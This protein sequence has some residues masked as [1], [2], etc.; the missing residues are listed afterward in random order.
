M[1]RRSLVVQALAA[2]LLVQLGVNIAEA[3]P[4]FARQYDLQCNA[5]HTRPPRL[6]RFGEQ[7]H[8]MGFQIPSAARPE[9]V[10]GTLRDDGPVKTLIDSL[11]LRIVG[12]LFEYS[13]SPR[14]T[15]TKFEPPHEVELFITRP[16]TPS[17]SIYVELEYEPK[18]VGFSRTR[19]FVEREH[20]FG[21][22][23][24]A[25][26]MWNM[27][28]LLG[29]LGAPT[30]KMGGQ[31]MVGRHGGFSMHGPMIMA[32]KVDPNTNFS[33]PTN[34]QLIEATELE[35]EKE[36]GAERGEVHRLPVVP[37]A[38]ASKFFGLFKNRDEREPQ[39]VTDQVMYNTTGTAGAEFHAMINDV[40]LAQVGFLRENEGFNTYG[41][42][43]FDIL[44]RKEL[45]FNVSALLNWGFGVVRG[46]DP[47]DHDH[48]GVKRL[49]RLRYGIAANA[50][51]NA[52]DVYGALIFDRLYGVP[53]ELRR[54]F[55]RSAGGRGTLRH[56]AEGR[57]P[58]ARRQADSQPHLPGG[59]LPRP[60]G[61]HPGRPPVR[62]G[63]D[64]PGAPQT[65]WRRRASG[66]GRPRRA[67]DGRHP[68]GTARGPDRPGPGVL[69]SIE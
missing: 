42:L 40:L 68:C 5:C 44:D 13:E 39:L 17:L 37:Y 36:E 54:E 26:F 61:P 14:E 63:D 65:R 30:M 50:R 28:S 18:S 47:D 25:F 20:E 43:R 34:R 29:A 7:F 57:W 27:G 60:R 32:G 8:M 9:G 15:E 22:G 48:P 49:D 69:M 38:F 16:I 67:G 41:M 6:N 31:T 56:R 21:L 45:T 66:P 55:D 59:V 2:A 1:S 11:A 4:A 24:E 10:V 12:G 3:V 64:D 62:G 33:Y 23:K 51:W 19:G 46:P 53:G 52:L 35:I 58:A